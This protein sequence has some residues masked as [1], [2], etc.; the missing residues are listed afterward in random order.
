MYHFITIISSLKRRFSSTTT[1][2][3]KLVVDLT[4]GFFVFCDFA[5]DNYSRIITMPQE[6]S[7]AL[8]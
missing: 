4:L 7:N 2:T 1:T 6:I 3:I 5:T 8:W